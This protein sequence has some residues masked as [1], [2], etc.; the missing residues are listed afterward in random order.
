MDLERV[1]E[2]VLRCGL[3]LDGIVS[4][5]SVEGYSRVAV[6][7]W[8]CSAREYSAVQYST[9]PWIESEVPCTRQP[10]LGLP[11][12]VPSPGNHSIL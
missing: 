10:N 3:H 5:G 6:Q 9:V 4:A 8:N 12:L 7:S 11:L 1:S 2:G